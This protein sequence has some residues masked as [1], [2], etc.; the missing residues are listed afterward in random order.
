MSRA[1]WWASVLVALAFTV[2]VGISWSM[3]EVSL[4]CS[5]IGESQSWFRCEDRLVDVLGI[6]PL[7]GLGL[8]LVLPPVVAALAMRRRVSWLVVAVLVGVAIAGLANW[9]SLWGSLLFAVL[10]AAL[11]AVAAALQGRPAPGN[12]RERSVAAT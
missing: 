3:A 1:V 6:W 9:T 8:L 4:S 2:W 7:V 12:S 5:K 11:G 10:L